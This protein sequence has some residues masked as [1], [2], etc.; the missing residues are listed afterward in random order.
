MKDVAERMKWL[1]TEWEKIFLYHTFTNN[2]YT[3]C[4]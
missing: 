2:W 3:E 4:I 1:A